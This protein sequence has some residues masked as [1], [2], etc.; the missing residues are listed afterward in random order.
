M[1]LT[2]RLLR[3]DFPSGVLWS[4]WNSGELCGIVGVGIAERAAAD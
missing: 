4:L 3:I 2:K 1:S